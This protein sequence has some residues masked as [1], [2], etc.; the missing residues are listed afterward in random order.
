ML[1]FLL[2]LRAAIRIKPS[3]NNLGRVGGKLLLHASIFASIFASILVA[4]SAPP[5]LIEA[6]T[7]DVTQAYETVE[8]RLTQATAF[9]STP[10]ETPQP[11]PSP[12]A[13]SNPGG[14]PEP[15][16][17]V[18]PSP[19]EIC[20]KAAPG[21]PMIDVNVEDGTEMQA[22]QRFTKIWR[23]NN[24]GACTWTREY[25]AIWFYGTK[26]GDST[27]VPLTK[28]V[29]PG[30]SIEIEVEMVAPL[31][32]GTYRSDWKLQ[33]DSGVSFGIGPSGNSTFWVEIEVVVPPT[34][35]PAPTSI[36]TDTPEPTSPPQI[37]ETVAPPSDVKASASLTLDANS[38]LDL[39][40]G[41][42]NPE[43]GA[44]LSYQP[45]ENSNHWLTPLNGFLLGV[46]GSSEP[47]L[48]ICQAATKSSAPIA[49]GSLSSGTILCYQTDSGL[50]G[51]LRLVEFNEENS[52]I[53]IDLLTWN[54][55]E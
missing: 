31:V 2:E 15:E 49:V 26:L 54:L 51:W 28:N 12:T 29:A 41:I 17:T 9:T 6:P 47:T 33:N 35:T 16:V 22:G 14:S 23:L 37:T 19:T 45:D 7:L 55:P 21:Y 24:A 25:Q 46:Y 39:E 32:P 10:I 1:G 5:T 3:S 43:S 30:E 13:T 50:P 4:C 20:D 53:A 48:E 52:S 34:E 38:T 8:A 44:D 27:A 40:D 36:P 18:T 42:I 11:P